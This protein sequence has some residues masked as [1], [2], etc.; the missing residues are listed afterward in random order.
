MKKPL[1]VPTH[2]TLPFWNGLN[3]GRVILRYCR[4]CDSLFHYPRTVCPECLSSAL[5][6]R[7]VRGSGT[8]YTYTISRRPTHPLFTDEVPQ[9][10]AVVE[11]DEGPRLTTTLVEV[12]ESDIRIGMPIEPVFERHEKEHITLLRYR[13]T[14]ADLR[15]GGSPASEDTRIS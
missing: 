8:L 15:S 14:Q 1:P 12:A 7:Q 9:Y 2:D 11:L 5:G 6:W 3:E 4:N 10:L 13:P